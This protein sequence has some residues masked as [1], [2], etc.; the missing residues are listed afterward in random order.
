VTL[1]IT[2][3][4]N[5][6]RKPVSDRLHMS[7]LPTGELADVA[8]AWCT[9]IDGA[10]SRYAAED[11]YGGRGFQEAVT[12]SE[13]LD[14]RLL[15]VSAGVGLVDASTKIP[16]YACTIVAGGGDSVG[17]RIAGGAAPADWWCALA[18]RSPFSLSIAGVAADSTGLICAALSDTYIALLSGDLIALPPAELQRLRLFTR[19]PLAR[20]PD[21]L[22]PF[23]M[24]YD[25]RLEG[26]DSPIK[27][28][29]SDFSGRALHHFAKFVHERGDARSAEEHADA[30][31]AA[32]AG[33]RPAPHFER[34]RHD[35]DAL[36]A[37]IAKHW[38]EAN[39]SSSRLLRVFRDEL[40]IACEQG[41]FAALVRDVRGSRL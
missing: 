17:S 6:K 8:T 28:T 37:L 26:P 31:S 11:V 16:P 19:A 20:V 38:G 3:C 15:I 4:T 24:P 40:N 14:A 27:G 13:L 23:V 10:T 12:A 25:N 39:G 29:R 1:V 32:Q 34:I 7:S 35:D 33:W 41:R 30:V 21:P 5:R 18:D 9:R 22:Q 36:K 2:T